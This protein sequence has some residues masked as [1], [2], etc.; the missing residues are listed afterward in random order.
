[1]ILTILLDQYMDVYSK[2]RSTLD[3]APLKRWHKNLVADVVRKIIF[4]PGVHVFGTSTWSSKSR[5]A[6]PFSI[7]NGE[8][9]ND[10]CRAEEG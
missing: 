5:E 2:Q 7:V 9:N 6:T 10:V 3:N 1:M 8:G 4:H